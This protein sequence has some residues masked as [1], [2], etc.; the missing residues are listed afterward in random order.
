LDLYK[1]VPFQARTAV[2]F[3]IN[4]EITKG[5]IAQDEYFK[6]SNGSLKLFNSGTELQFNSDG[7]VQ[8]LIK[9]H[10]GNPRFN[11]QFTNSQ[12]ADLDLHVITPSGKEIFFGN[13]AADG[14]RLD[15]DCTCNNCPVG[16]NENI[17][18]DL[19]TAPHGV[20]QFWVQYY[21]ACSGG[22]GAASSFTLRRI[23]NQTIEA[24]YNGT[25]VNGKSQVYSFTY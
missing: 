11:L 4:G 13:R 24:T 19:G 9:G 17:Y 12:N 23:N 14:G 7:S 5:T 21:G 1:V 20:Y 8:E 18:W 2:T 3:N 25:L 6:T 15:I 10:P 22:S 16:P